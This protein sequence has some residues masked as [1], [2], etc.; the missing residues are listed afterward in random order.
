M[1]LFIDLFI[2][3]LKYYIAQSAAAQGHLRAFH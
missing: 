3:G 2:E 1:Y